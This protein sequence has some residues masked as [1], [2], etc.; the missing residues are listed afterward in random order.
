MVMENTRYYVQ[1]S[2]GRYFAGHAE[3]GTAID[4]LSLLRA[5]PPHLGQLRA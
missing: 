4:I 1:E 2:K 3:L 5:V